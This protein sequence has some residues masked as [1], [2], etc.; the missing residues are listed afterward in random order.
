M[1]LEEYEK[2]ITNLEQSVDS[3]SGE[4]DQMYINDLMSN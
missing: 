3:M 1:M 4:V 2:R